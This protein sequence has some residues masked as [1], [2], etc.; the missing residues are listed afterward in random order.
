MN[1][2]ETDRPITEDVV[3]LLGG[4]PTAYAGIWHFDQGHGGPLVRWFKGSGCVEHGS[5]TLRTVNTAARLYHLL[6][7]LGFEVPA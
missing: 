3:K 7:A 1:D 6:K 4:R 2:I 5:T